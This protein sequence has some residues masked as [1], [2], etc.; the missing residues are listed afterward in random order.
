MNPC[1]VNCSPPFLPNPLL[2]R[3]MAAAAEEEG[4]CLQ[5]PEHVASQVMVISTPVE[6]RDVAKRLLALASLADVACLD[7]ISVR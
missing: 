2:H 3:K 7:S 6:L 5:L 1:P 4:A